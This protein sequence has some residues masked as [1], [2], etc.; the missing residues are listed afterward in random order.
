[1]ELKRDAEA[2]RTGR[3]ASAVRDIPLHDIDGQRI[4]RV[5]FNGRVWLHDLDGDKEIPL[6]GVKTAEQREAEGWR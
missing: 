3:G 2:L 4:G 5:S 6:P 1:M